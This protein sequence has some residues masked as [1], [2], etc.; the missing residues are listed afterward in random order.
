VVGYGFFTPG[1]TPDR[2]I[3]MLTTRFGALRFALR[4]GP[5]D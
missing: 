1:E 4:P 2:A 3:T 5:A